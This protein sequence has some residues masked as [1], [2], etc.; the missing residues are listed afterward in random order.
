MPKFFLQDLRLSS[1]ALLCLLL[2]C[3]CGCGCDLAG[4]QSPQNECIILTYNV[5]NLFDTLVSGNE[6]PEFTPEDGWSARAYAKRLE[7]IS[8]TITQGHRYLPDIVVFQEIEHSGVLEDLLVGPLQSRGYQWYAATDDM[9]SAIQTGVISRFPIEGARVHQSLGL[10]SALEV[11]LE[12]NNERMVLFAIHAKSRRE[13]VAETES[14]RIE[15]ARVISERVRQLLRENPLLPIVIAG[16]FNESADSY[17]REE[18]AMQ[19]ALVP[20]TANKAHL[21]R[22]MG[23]LMVGGT[24]PSEGCWYTWWLDSSQ[25]LM[26]GSSGSYWYQGVWETFDQILLSPAFFDRYGLEFKHGY[27]VS[28]DWVFDENGHPYRYEVHKESGVSDHLPVAVV[29]SNR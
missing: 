20:I 2:L 4:T 28:Q 12:I 29:L 25:A 19:T 24:A 3:L 23:S 13:G 8:R 7:T 9:G 11:E 26:A 27:V 17:F 16:D 21:Y 18:Q 5:Q 10:R 15:L 6:Y 22:N 1:I 14:K